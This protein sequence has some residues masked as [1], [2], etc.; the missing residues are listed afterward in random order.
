MRYRI[1]TRSILAVD[2]ELLRHPMS[3]VAIEDDETLSWILTLRK[4]D[5]N[6]LTVTPERYREIAGSMKTG[7]EA[8]VLATLSGVVEMLNAKG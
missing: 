2:I 6:R 4:A 7:T 5:I 3:I 1:R 8:E